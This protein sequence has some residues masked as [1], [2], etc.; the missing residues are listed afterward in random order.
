LAAAA[1]SFRAFVSSRRSSEPAVLEPGSQEEIN[2]IEHKISVARLELDD[3]LQATRYDALRR[4]LDSGNLVGSILVRT[5]HFLNGWRPVVEKLRRTV[6]ELSQQHK[7]LIARRR[8]VA[9]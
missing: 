7:E 1:H 8:E 2:A 6:E 5:E 9:R 3:F 4:E